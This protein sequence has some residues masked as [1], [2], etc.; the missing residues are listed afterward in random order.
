[1][2]YARI[3]DDHIIDVQEN[4]PESEALLT[5]PGLWVTGLRHQ[6]VALQRATGWYQIVSGER[7]DDDDM[8]TA[9]RSIELVDGVPTEVWYRRM[10]TQREL[11][12]RQL[13]KEVAPNIDT[14][15]EA[16]AGLED[17]TSVQELAAVVS[18][19]AN[20]VIRLARIQ[21]GEFK[22]TNCGMR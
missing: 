11:N 4:L 17:V 6:P 19:L 21:A 20:Q 12:E 15:L 2:S 13:V 9:N 1:M 22:T 16:V 18:V 7:T 3:I 14:M 10:W 5:D 8:Y